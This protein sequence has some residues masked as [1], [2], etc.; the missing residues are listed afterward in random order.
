M[1]AEAEQ[2]E[3]DPEDVAACT[4]GCMRNLMTGN[5]YCTNVE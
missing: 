1:N 2:S 4:L 3:A 5:A